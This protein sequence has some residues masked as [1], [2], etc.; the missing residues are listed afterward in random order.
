M[1]INVNPLL[2]TVLGKG[3]QKYGIPQYGNGVPGKWKWV[4]KIVIPGK[5]VDGFHC[6]GTAG[7]FPDVLLP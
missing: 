5:P 4:L 2:W 6:R 1:F 3:T 7:Q